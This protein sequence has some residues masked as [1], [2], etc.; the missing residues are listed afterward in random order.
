MT[1]GPVRQVHYSTDVIFRF[2]SVHLSFK[3]ARSAQPSESRY[4]F[5]ST[6]PVFGLGHNM[7]RFA[8]FALGYTQFLHHFLGYKKVAK[9][10]VIIMSCTRLYVGSTERRWTK[11]GN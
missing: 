8:S 5:T 10:I 11:E 2:Q 9:K 6:A 1:T 7:G 3:L 4:S